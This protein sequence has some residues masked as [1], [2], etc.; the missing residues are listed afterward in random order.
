MVPVALAILS[1]ADAGVTLTPDALTRP[2]SVTA[3]RLEVRAKENR[4][5]YSGNARAVRDRAVIRCDQ[6]VIQYG[7]MQQVESAEATGNVEV[8][9]GEKWAK[10]DKATFDNRSGVLVV[11]GRVEAK[12][13]QGRVAG[14]RVVF[15][16]GSDVLEV[17]DARTLVDDPASKKKVRI[18]APKL[19]VELPKNRATW[20]GRVRAKR[21]S[22]DLQAD[23]LVAHYFGDEVERL[24]ASGNVEVKDGELWAKGERAHFDNRTGVLVVTGKVEAKE[25][26]NQMRGTKV[27]FSLG[28]GRLEVEN[29]ET[30]F[31]SKKGVPQLKAPNR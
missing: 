18:D 14:S 25:G 11:T 12:S 10:G 22:A 1:A 23:R 19:F 24:E 31:E 26:A 9:D 29:A 15:T 4:A 27:T 5:I 21:G 3:D 8:Q 17:D 6:A 2:V 16:V 28:S 13:G 20:S 7:R 30:V